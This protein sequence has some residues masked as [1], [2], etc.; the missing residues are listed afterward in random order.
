MIT[1]GPYDN[2]IDIGNRLRAEYNG[3]FIELVSGGLSLGD[4]LDKLRGMH[5]YSAVAGF[6]LN[7]SNVPVEF[8]PVFNTVAANDIGACPVTGLQPAID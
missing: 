5:D 6:V 7:C 3:I 8:I 1:Y 2:P 4:A